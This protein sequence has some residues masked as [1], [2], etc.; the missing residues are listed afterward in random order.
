MN[1]NLRVTNTAK[2]TT[3]IEAALVIVAGRDGDALGDRR[4]ASRGRGRAPP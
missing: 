3:M 1:T 4:A 2:T